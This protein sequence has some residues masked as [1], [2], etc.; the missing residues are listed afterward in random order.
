M[1]VYRRI[2]A[3]DDAICYGYAEGCRENLPQISVHIIPIIPTL[4]KVQIEC[5]HVSQKIHFIQEC[6]KT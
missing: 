3:V 6:H 2:A 5:F 1:L 4:Y